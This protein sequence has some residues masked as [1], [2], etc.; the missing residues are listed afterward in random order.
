MGAAPSIVRALVTRRAALQQPGQT[1]TGQRRRQRVLADRLQ[2]GRSDISSRPAGTPDRLAGRVHDV[3]RHL[4]C[5]ARHPAGH[6]ARPA[7]RLAGS[8]ANLA[9]GLAYLADD[10]ADRVPRRT[11]PALAAD[12]ASLA[13]SVVLRPRLTVVLWPRLIAVLSIARLAARRTR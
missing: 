5:A 12:V 1:H 2:Q 10:V 11:T 9:G 4:A 8:A 7:D 6:L 3:T 13:G